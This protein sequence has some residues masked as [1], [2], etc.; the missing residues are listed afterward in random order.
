MPDPANHAIFLSY[1]HEDTDAARRI[2]DALRSHGLEVW[3]D[4]NELRGGDTWDQKIRR[5]IKECAL[6]VPLISAN[7][8]SRKE[9]YFRLEWKLAAER[10]HLM[11]EGVPFLAPVV[12]D[13]TGESGALVPGEFLRVQWTRLPGALVTPQFIDQ[14]KRLLGGSTAP[15]A[16][17]AEAG[18]GRLTPS[19][20][21]DAQAPAKSGD[22]ARPPGRSS[23][24]PVMIGLGISVLALIGY[25]ALRPAVKTPAAPAA[26][27]VAETKP[28]PAPPAPALEKI[29]N[30]S[31]A[32][33]PLD[34]MSDDKDTGFFADGV[35]E[36]LLTNLA[37]IPELKVVSR[38]SVMQ[39]RGTKKT[40]KE[41]GEELGVAYVLEGSVRRAGNKVRVTGQLINTRTDEHV[42]AES[43]DRD[44][45]DIFSIQAELSKK[46][47]GALS[48]A[49]SPQTQKFLERKP[50]E[51]PVA[52]DFYLRGRD[53][54]NRSVPG[55]AEPLREQEAFYKS[56]VQQDP[57]F[58]AAWGEL[59]VVHAL[60][61]F[62]GLD[63][64]PARLAEGDAAMAK[65]VQLAPEAP[66]V[67]RSV[68]TYA[69]YAH[70]DYAR[71]TAQYEKLARLQPNDA[72][73]FSS[74]GLIQRR[75]G[76]WA[77]SLGNLRRAVELDPANSGYVRN[78]M[79][80]L[81]PGRRWDDA[82]AAHQRLVALLPDHLHEKFD[83]ADFEFDATGSLQAADELL[84]RLSPEDRD[85]PTGIYFR[86]NWAI[87]RGDYAEFKR[88]DQLQPSFE[89]EEEPALSAIIAA[90]SYFAHGD[91]A[92]VKARLATPLAE[93]RARAERE[94]TNEKAWAFLAAMESLLGNADTGLRFARHAADLRPVASDAVDGPILLFVLA[95]VYARNGD[96]DHALSLLEQLLRIPEPISV[97]VL[98][99]LPVFSTLHG[100]P[101]FEALLNDPKNNA[102]LF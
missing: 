82:R 74:L 55:I 56:A 101:Q 47:A 15:M 7:T 22:P 41:I 75:Q 68:G 21:S 4:Q 28:L 71:A 61:S 5:Q 11:A 63:G 29:S 102:P 49:I 58:G 31:I 65:A 27:A 57:K 95:Q 69:Y 93:W 59:A 64:T 24:N 35:H 78:L 80:S 62:W 72:T 13:A 96:K 50:T 40:I 23:P 92:A 76:H 33:L 38:T 45:T 17:S 34:N 70:R 26:P 100:D 1:A 3:F 85:S 91:L 25:I 48:A 20:A 8:Q 36:D 86:K 89:D 10:T 19:A 14:I 87:Y 30:K 39:Y 97:A 43:F 52:Y 18:R 42:W 77:E 94:P 79:H 51:N 9:G 12:P 60:H 83:L 88:L 53:L 67:I 84:A 66:E 32:V 37:L 98:R 99:V 54:F 44:L 73:V 46:I 16:A 90:N 81:A 2:A 6:F